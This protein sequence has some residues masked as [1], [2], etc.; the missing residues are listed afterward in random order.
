MS[1]S[2]RHSANPHRNDRQLILV[3]DGLARRL[4]HERQAALNGTD[5]SSQ[6]TAGRA[7]HHLPTQQCTTAWQTRGEREQI[8]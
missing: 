4:K 5:S 3:D 1:T 8:L 6:S 2:A 7:N